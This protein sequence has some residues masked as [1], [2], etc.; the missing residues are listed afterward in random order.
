MGFSSQEYEW[1]A[2]PFSRGSFKA[3]EE[4]PDSQVSCIGRRFFT[5]SAPWEEQWILCEYPFKLIDNLGHIWGDGE[6][7]QSNICTFFCMI[8]C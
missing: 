4:I 3:R 2:I 5:I 7:M 6:E 8:I 1:V